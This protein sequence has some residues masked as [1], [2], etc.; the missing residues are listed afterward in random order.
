MIRK[1]RRIISLGFAGQAALVKHTS[2]NE[3]KIY[4][5]EQENEPQA[6]AKAALRNNSQTHSVQRAFADNILAESLGNEA[7]TNRAALE[8]KQCE[9][10]RRTGDLLSKL[11]SEAISRL[12]GLVSS[13]VHGDE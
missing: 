6:K 10:S 3:S 11:S 5:C 13:T 8:L 7:E 12:E 4:V 9:E 1:S 2:R